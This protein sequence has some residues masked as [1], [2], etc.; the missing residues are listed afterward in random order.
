ME[1]SRTDDNGED[2]WAKIVGGLVIGKSENTEEALDKASP[3]GVRT[4]RTENFN[5]SGVKF[6][7]YNWNKAAGM[8]TCSHCW[9]DNNTDSGARTITV[10][11]LYFDE[12]TVKKRVSYTTPFRTI[13]F[14]KSGGLTGKGPNTWFLPY[15][16]HL[17][18]SQ[19]E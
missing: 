3:V 9:H 10:D 14:D 5:M 4:P 15:F 1:M 13:F 8:H 16:K 18:V 12:A 7:N 19:C 2:N 11:K 6:Y 17:L